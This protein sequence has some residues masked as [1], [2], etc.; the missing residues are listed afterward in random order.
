MAVVKLTADNFEQEVVE[1]KGIT[2]VD[3]FAEW[4]G[5]CKMMSPIY[6]MVANAI[7]EVKF[8]KLNIDNATNIAVKYKV[9]NIPTIIVFKDGEVCKVNIGAMSKS[10][11]E[12]MVKECQML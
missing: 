12:G 9:M 4:C 10:E 7:P 1:S 2:V 8:C 3:F 6:D 5:P 11:L